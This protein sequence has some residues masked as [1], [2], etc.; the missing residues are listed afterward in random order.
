MEMVL[1]FP[2]MLLVRLALQS[3]KNLNE[4]RWFNMFRESSFVKWFCIDKG[5]SC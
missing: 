2:Q 4:Q 3:P 5:L 1:Q